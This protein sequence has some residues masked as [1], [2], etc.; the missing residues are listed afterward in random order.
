MNK[1]PICALEMQVFT[2]PKLL[3]QLVDC[4]QPQPKFQVSDFELKQCTV[5]QEKL[6]SVSQ[7]YKCE[8]IV[9]MRELKRLCKREQNSVAQG[10]VQ[11]S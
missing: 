6:C 9:C 10:A 3:A 7:S 1:F 2:Q 11:D 4:Q 5:N 8:F